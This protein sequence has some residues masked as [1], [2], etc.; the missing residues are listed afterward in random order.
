MS[1]Q[2]RSG[3]LTGRDS[4]ASK[5]PV[6]GQRAE[7]AWLPYLANLIVEPL[8]LLSVHP[9]Q[10]DKGVGVPLLHLGHLGGVRSLKIKDLRRDT[11]EFDLQGGEE[12]TRACAC[13]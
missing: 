2:R 7:E 10:L 13:A 11:L 4:E 6:R 5:R 1:E 3:F 8:T 12:V 9:T